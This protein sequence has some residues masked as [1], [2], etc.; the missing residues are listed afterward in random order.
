MPDLSL[1]NQLQTYKPW[2]TA[3]ADFIQRIQSF[4]TTT[5]QPFH[6]E[7]LEGHITASAFVV[8]SACDRLLLIHHRKLDRWLQPGGHCDGNPDTLAIALQEAQE[9]TGV[10]AI[11]SSAEIFDIDIHAIPSKGNVPEHWHYDVRYLLVADDQESL[12]HSEREAIAIAWVLI[13]DLAKVNPEESF[14]RVQAKLEG[15]TK[16]IF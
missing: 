9:E 13:A 16:P 7:T 5:P 4:L 14:Y 10:V 6:R 15:K 8:N 2:D 11:P 12:Q 3:E 1:L